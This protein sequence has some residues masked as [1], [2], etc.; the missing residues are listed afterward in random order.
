MTPQVEDSARL[1]ELLGA[2]HTGRATRLATHSA[3]IDLILGRM[4]CAR[5]SMWRFSAVDDELQL[6]CFA[7]KT[8]DSALDVSDRRLRRSEYAGCFDAIAASGMYASSDAMADPVLQPMRDSYLV[9]NHI[10]SLLDA[11]YLLNSRAYGMVCCE[12]TSLA[13][14][15]RP[16]DVVAL[17]AIVNKL[18]LLMWN[19]P[20]PVLRTMPSLPLFVAPPAPAPPSRR[21]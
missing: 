10:V 1:Q 5:V 4:R 15:W 8:P 7:S 17:R 14:E 3:V 6:L 19:A 11:A 20:E 12:E 9:P 16:A 2:F 18:A 13:R 21:R